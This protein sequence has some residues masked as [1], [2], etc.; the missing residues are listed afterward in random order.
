LIP[1]EVPNDKVLIL[2]DTDHTGRAD[3]VTVFAD[4]LMIPTG[5]E[6]APETSF[7]VETKGGDEKS[8]PRK[9]KYFCS[10]CYVGEG[11]KLWL[12]TDTDGD[13]HADKREVVLR[14]FGTGDNHQNI[15]SFR[16]SPGGDLMFSQGLHAR[17]R[18]E[19]P[20]GIVPLDAAGFWR[21]RPLEQRIDAFYGGHA[22]PQNPWDSR[23]RTG[24][25]C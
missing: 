13:G 19:T 25:R 1:G 23:G 7:E 12:L 14:G 21:F 17:A 9:A 5:L 11:T 3:K 18:I 20:Y 22:E 15:N 2:E 8:S 10:A 6:I 4:H 24:A 16:W